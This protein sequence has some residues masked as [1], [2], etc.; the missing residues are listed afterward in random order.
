MPARSYS[1]GHQII[2]RGKRW[3]YTD[4]GA[5][6]SEDRACIKCGGLPTPEGHDACLGRIEGVISAC[7]GHGVNEPEIITEKGR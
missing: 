5:P 2:F 1:R 7:C 4:N 3:Y 6:L